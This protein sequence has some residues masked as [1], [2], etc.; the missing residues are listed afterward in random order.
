M[1]IIDQSAWGD[2]QIPRN[3]TSVGP[4]IG[5]HTT[6]VKKRAFVSLEGSNGTQPSTSSS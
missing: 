4:E 1:V 2:M 3:V 5:V 6:S